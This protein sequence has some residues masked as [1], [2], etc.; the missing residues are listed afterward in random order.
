MLFLLLGFHAYL[1][2][3]HLLSY[4]LIALAL[5]TYE[6][7]YFVFLVAPLTTA[8]SWG[9][10]KTSELVRH[11]VIVVAIFLAAFLIRSQLGDDR[12]ADAQGWALILTPLRHMVVGPVVSLSSYLLRSFQALRAMNPTQLIW[13]IPAFLIGLVFLQRAQ[14]RRA[15]RVV[16]VDPQPIR[17]DGRRANSFS[18]FI[19][20]WNQMPV[21]KRRL[22]VLL[23][24]AILMVVLAY[25]LTFTT[26]SFAIYGRATRVHFA[27]A[28]GVALFWGVVLYATLEARRGSIARLITVS[29]FASILPLMFVFGFQIQADYRLAWEHQQKFWEEI[30]PLIAPAKNGTAILVAPSVFHDVEQIDANTWNLPRVLPQLFDFPDE[31]TTPPMVYRLVPGWEKNILNVEGKFDLFNLTVTA[32]PSTYR[33][34]HSSTA[35]FIGEEDGSMERKNMITIGGASYSLFSGNEGVLGQFEGALLLRLLGLRPTPPE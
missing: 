9:K 30:L 11:G 15:D 5:L 33:V 18:Q 35:I 16:N 26:R 3:R 20:K 24:T 31:W 17:A 7:T 22:M 2:R 13:V 21:E 23:A 25:P 32:P 29:I 27:A 34:V 1:S 10:D 8:T 6:T 19:K 4:L 12:I 14:I 28:P